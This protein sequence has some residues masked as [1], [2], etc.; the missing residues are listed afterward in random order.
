MFLFEKA[1]LRDIHIQKP[2]AAT[3]EIT[4]KVSWLIDGLAAFQLFIHTETYGGW[5]ESLMHFI[6]SPEVA[7][8]SIVGTVTVTNREL[9]IKN[10]TQRSRR[11]EHMKIIIQGFEQYMP[12]GMK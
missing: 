9:N 2:N 11:E 4:P 8:C 7:E 10:K 12:A 3:R 5:I 1:S 6:T